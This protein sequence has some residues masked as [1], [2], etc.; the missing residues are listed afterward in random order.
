MMCTEEITMTKLPIAFVSLVTSACCCTAAG[1][2]FESGAEEGSTILFWTK[3]KGMEVKIHSLGISQDRV[4]TGRYA[5]KLDVTLTGEHYAYFKVP[6]NQRIEAGRSYYASGRIFVEQLPARDRT[7]I[8]LGATPVTWYGPGR[9]RSTTGGSL[10]D[11]TTNSTDEWIHMESP[12]LGR[13]VPASSASMGLPTD[14]IDIDNIFLGIQGRFEGDRVVVYLDDVALRPVTEKPERPVEVG[15]FPVLEGIFPFGMYGMGGGFRDAD[16]SGTFDDWFPDP[17]WRTLPDFKRHYINTVIGGARQIYPDSPEH[18]WDELETVLDIL[19]AHGIGCLPITYFSRYYRADLDREAVEEAIRKRVPRYVDKEALLGWYIIDEPAATEAALEDYLWAAGVI[20]EVDPDHPVTTGG[21]KYNIFFDRHRPVVIFDRYPLRENSRSPW[22]IADITRLIYREA[23]GP[24]WYIAPAFHNINGEYPRPTPAEFRLMCYAAVAN[25]AKGLLFF[26]YR[27]RPGWFRSAGSG[28]VDVFESNTELWD[29]TGRLGFHL[30]AVGPL[31]LDTE[32]AEDHPVQIVTDEI[33]IEWEE[34]IAAVSVG[35]LKD[36][37]ANRIFLVVYNNDIEQP[38]QARI[39]VAA[40]GGKDAIL[41]DLY[42]LAP[43]DY[44]GT[45]AV[46]RAPGDGRIYLLAGEKEVMACKEQILKSRF[47]H[48]KETAAYDLY[49]AGLAGLAPGGLEERL[50]DAGSAE[51]VREVRKALDEALAEDPVYAATRHRLDAIQQ[52]LSAVN[53]LYEDKI[54]SLESTAKSPSRYVER[55]HD[56]TVPGIRAY[57]D[58]LR[59]VGACYFALRNLYLMGAYRELD[60][61]VTALETV[62]RTLADNARASFEAG[63]G[64]REP[65]VPAESLDALQGKI[66]VLKENAQPLNFKGPLGR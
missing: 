52:R 22:S 16:A 47:D 33:E 63:E 28:L 39:T 62:S 51:Q 49:F 41:F 38:R 65:A 11:S 8:G 32:L 42:D 66:V 5:M 14:T 45:F 15:E 46:E 27:H 17:L 55:D 6:V 61:A 1:P 64:I 54:T 30:S 60:E 2:Y 19:G 18:Y 59:D 40:D 7:L 25:G 44:D 13:V 37:E 3:A 36:Q 4:H 21:N 48:E 53:R 29:E 50:R 57:L 58:R 24:V 35:V 12:D 43:V 10:F 31:L 20:N 34:R 26:N 9:T 23:P 56:P